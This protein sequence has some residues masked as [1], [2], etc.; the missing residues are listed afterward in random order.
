VNL[1]ADMDE[2]AAAYEANAAAEAALEEQITGVIEELERIAQEQREQES[3]SSYWIDVG[4]ISSTGDYLWPSYNSNYITSPHGMR[5]HPILQEYRTHNGV[6]I[7]ADY[8][9]D[10]VASDSGV[11]ITST[12]DDSYGNYI[13]IAH[14]NNRYTLYAHMSERYAW[15]GQEVSQG[16]TIGLVGMTGWA[17]GPHLHFEI[18]EGGVRIDPLDYFWNYVEGW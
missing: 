14:G 18:Y 15:E 2:F 8:G 13:M 3:Y 10:I 16:E 7:G 1:A 4:A 5:W 9:S 6:D 11:V 12:Y 17:T